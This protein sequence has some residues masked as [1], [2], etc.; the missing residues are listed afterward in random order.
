MKEHLFS[1]LTMFC[2]IVSALQYCTI[3]RPEIAF[4][5]NKLC[6]ILAIPSEVYW[7]TVKIVLK[8]L[9][10]TLDH[11]MSLQKSTLLNLIAFTDAN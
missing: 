3:T 5:L 2:S 8:Y 1:N 10:G 4:V 11:G 6:Q 9:K 7:L